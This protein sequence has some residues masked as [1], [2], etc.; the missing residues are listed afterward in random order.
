M[1]HSHCTN[2]CTDLNRSNKC[3]TK[4]LTQE[5]RTL[6]LSASLALI[7]SYLEIPRDSLIPRNPANHIYLKMHDHGFAVQAIDMD[8]LSWPK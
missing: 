1:A 2:I 5:C 4:T 6:I 7:Y 3:D 8:N